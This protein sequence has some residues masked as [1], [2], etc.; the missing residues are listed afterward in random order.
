[1]LDQIKQST[2]FVPGY[3]IQEQIKKEAEK[4]GSEKALNK[5]AQ[6]LKNKGFTIFQIVE[7]TGITEE[8]AQ[9]LKAKKK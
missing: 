1:M 9:K 8:E 2:R 6:Q 7:L 4:I 3:K 5:V